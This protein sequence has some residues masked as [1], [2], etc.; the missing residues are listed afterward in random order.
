MPYLTEEYGNPSSLYRFGR[1]TP[2]APSSRPARRLRMCWAAEPCE[3]LLHRRRHR[4]RQLGPQGD[5]ALFAKAKG[6]NHFITSAVEHH[7]LL[8]SAQ[9]LQKEGFEVTFLPVDREGQLDPA[10]GPRGHPAGDW[11]CLDHVCQQRD[12]HHL[13]HQRNRRH[14]P[15]GRGAVPHR[16]GA[17]RGP[18]CPSMSRR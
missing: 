10:A 14:L 8:H 11:P 1:T 9:R 15:P 5:R 6:K 17:G 7:A 18:S 13:P 4:G 3:I 2:S 16:R 12:R